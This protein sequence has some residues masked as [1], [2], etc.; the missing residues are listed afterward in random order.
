MLAM[1]HENK[2]IKLRLSWRLLAHVTRRHRELHHLGDL[3]EDQSQIVVPPRDGLAPQSGPHSEPFHIAPR[4]S[5]PALCRSYAKGYLLPDFY[6]GATGISGRFTE[7]LLLR[8][9]QTGWGRAGRTSVK[10]RKHRRT[11]FYGARSARRQFQV[12][13][14]LA[15][16][17][18]CPS[19]RGNFT[20][21]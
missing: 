15:S 21:H 7:G 14:V 10:W 8:R 11:R 3:S 9:V 2:W 16:K 20:G 5:S 19:R 6:S 1:I 12:S 13:I 18:K 17:N 4:P